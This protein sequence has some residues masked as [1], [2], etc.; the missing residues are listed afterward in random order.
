[1]ADKEDLHEPTAELSFDEWVTRNGGSVSFIPLLAEFDF[2]LR[3]SLQH[4]KKEA[5]ELFK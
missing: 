2:T 1:M 5:T 4:L 3:L